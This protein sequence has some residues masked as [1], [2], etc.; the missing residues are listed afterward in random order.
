MAMKSGRFH[1]IWQISWWN[2]TDFMESG[3]F[4]GHEIWQISWN[5]ADFM[6]SGGFHGHEIWR[7]SPSTPLPLNAKYPVYFCIG[8]HEI[9]QIS[10]STTKY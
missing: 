8:F 9:W 1:G 2:L 7:I 4:H 6:E 3:G 10:W 5:L